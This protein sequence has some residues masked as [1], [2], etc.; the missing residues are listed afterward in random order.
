VLPRREVRLRLF[1]L[2]PIFL[3][4]GTLCRVLRDDAVFVAGERP[5][6]GRGDVRRAIGTTTLA[7]LS[8]RAIRWLYGRQRAALQAALVS[9]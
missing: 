4:V 5:R 2:W 8:D 9:G 1:C 6:L 3:A 7:V